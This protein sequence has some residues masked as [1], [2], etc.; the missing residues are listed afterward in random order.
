MRQPDLWRQSKFQIEGRQIRASKDAHELAR[1]SRIIA[2][3][4]AEFYTNAIPR[5][6]SGDL[7]DLGCGKA[8][9]LGAY[10][11][12]CSSILLADWDNSLHENPLLD[13]VIDM[14]QPLTSF[15]SNS[16]DVLILSDVLEHISEPK[17]LMGEIY[18]ILK[19]GGRLI[20]NVP[21]IYWIHE[22]PHDYYRYTRF[23]LERFAK[24]AGL[25]VAELVPLGGWIEVLADIC[26][27]LMA[28]V[29]LWYLVP[30]LHRVV[31]AINRTALGKKIA[32]RGGE[33]YPL[34]YGMVAV[35]P[36]IRRLP[37]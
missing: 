36:A 20:L 9:L 32:A 3:L 21:F 1:S 26:S 24:Q 5:W 33:L 14:N 10:R 25:E 6:V 7:A 28:R 23:A 31:M 29:R 35:K 13:L 2:D 19:P 34:G 12:Y 18:R 37:G 16:F 17:A 15:A 8:P 4:V 22:S 11:D 30:F 27:K